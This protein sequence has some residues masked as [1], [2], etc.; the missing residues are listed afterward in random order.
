VA[1]AE[2]EGNRYFPHSMAATAER[3]A[4]V[5]HASGS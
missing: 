1:A 2:D 5:D 3:E 4:D